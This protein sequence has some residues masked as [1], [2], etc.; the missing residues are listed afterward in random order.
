MISKLFIKNYAIINLLEIKFSKG[1]TTI[2]GETGAGKSIILGAL[3]LLLGNKFDSINFKDKSSKSIIEGIF[4]ISKLN[5]KFF[6]DNHNLDYS[7]ILIIRRE[8]LFEGK[9]RSFIND[10]PV[11]LE[12]LKKISFFLVDI[13]SQ[14]QNLIINNETFQIDLIDKFA[15]QKNT[16]FGKKLNNYKKLFK[17]LQFI[18][19]NL[20]DRKRLISLDSDISY[21][22][23]IIEDIDV[24]NLEPGEKEKNEIEYKRMSNTHNIKEVFASILFLLEGADNSIMRGLH[25]INSQLDDLQEY[26]AEIADLLS[27]VKQN[28]IDLDDVVMEIHNLNHSIYLDPQKLE[29]L[30]NR[31]NAINSLEKRLNV[32][33]VTA[34]LDKKNALQKEIDSLENIEESIKNLEKQV[35]E[36]NKQLLDKAKELSVVRKKVALDIVLLL[37]KDLLALGIKNPNIRFEINQSSNLLVNGIDKINLLFSANKGYELK[38]IIDVISGGEIARLMLCIKKQLFSIDSFS[39]IIFDEID[40]G[41]SGDIGRKMGRI[42]HNISLQGQV[43]CITHLPQIASLGDFHYRI[44]KVDGEK[45]SNTVIDKLEGDSRVSEIARMLSG[46]EVNLEAIANAKKMLDI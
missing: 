27:R 29:L 31:I 36:L 40:S 43:I 16:E 12:T 34:L 13:H 33:S 14:H 45:F 18:K 37:E 30:A 41:V 4:N 25:S 5:L 35:C 6:F 38:P 8:F 1:F 42:L 32:Y 2:T 21:K 17:Q 28:T 24:L 23:Q 19:H 44:S 11:K 46:E 39:T 9:S 3:N 26:G 22:K 20:E 10:S 7:D 15:I